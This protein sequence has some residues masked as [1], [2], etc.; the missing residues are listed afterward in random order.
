MK[1]VVA[2][3][4]LLVAGAI[5]AT[6]NCRSD[7]ADLSRFEPVSADVAQPGLPVGNAAPAAPLRPSDR[8][9]IRDGHFYTTGASRTRVRFFGVSLALSANFPSEADGEAV[10][11]RLSALGVNIVRLHAIDQ[12]AGHSAD[13]P[14]GVLVDAVHPQ[15]DARAV[16]DLS[17][18]IEQLGRHGIYVDLNLFANHTF[19]PLHPGD[20]IPPQSKPLPVFDAEMT[21]WQETYV[22]NL[23]TALHLRDSPN[24]ALVE[25][26]NESTLVDAWQE[27][28]LPKLITGRFRDELSEQWN[29]YCEARRLTCAALPLHRPAHDDDATRNAAQFFLELDQRYTDRM[30]AAVKTVLGNDVP[31]SGTQII[32]S[33]RW[34]HGGFANFDVN[35]AATFTDAH[36]YID[37]YD[38]PHRPWDWRDWRISNG[39]LGDVL[40]QMFLNVAF[41]R[42]AGRPFTVSEFNQPWPNEQT[43]DLLPLVTQF[44]VSQDWDGLIL[45]DYAH[46]RAWSRSTPSDFSL[47]GNLTQ[48][49][50]FAQCAAYFRRVAPD[51]PMGRTEITLSRTERIAAATDGIAGN[52]AQWI[53]KRFDLD[54]S[55]AMERQIAMKDDVQFGVHEIASSESSS[56]FHYA[57]EAR[58]FTFG[59]AYAAGVSGFLP[60]GRAINSSALDIALT[61]GDRGFATAFLTSQ[62]GNTLSAST[63]LLLT[64]PGATM[65]T[66]GGVPQRLTSIAM[67]GAWKTIPPMDG[68]G[69]S[70]S[71]YDVSGPVQVERVAGTIGLRIAARRV[72]ITGLDMRGKPLFL[73]PYRQ[74]GSTL[75]FDVNR[76][77]QPFAASYRIT[78]ER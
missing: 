9:V 59:S 19:A 44:A 75:T 67:T 20:A 51:T 56:Y 73:V 35:R 4:Y 62:D 3:R 32:H 5:I 66:V 34:N 42:V 12:P 6:S 52:L 61:P 39:W 46:D 76:G 15:L 37:H 21:A 18:F 63:Q 7:N 25:I 49:I 45:Y 54:P 36:F 30:V 31:V 65:G 13:G 77:N 17:R 1:F 29:A 43:S 50:Q 27:N 64:L 33:G 38:F 47:R 2:V 40:D 10:A 53:S 48:L 55:L 57:S 16:Q 24:L 71:L 69:P 41:A 70:A 68:A 23:L 28:T 74:N 14:T 8:I 60:V 22:R 72:S 26:N 78:V 58:I 11:R